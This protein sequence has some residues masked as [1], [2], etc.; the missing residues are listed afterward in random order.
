MGYCFLAECGGLGERNVAAV[1]GQTKGTL[2]PNEKVNLCRDPFGNVVIY[3]N[4]VNLCVAK[5]STF[6]DV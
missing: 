6:N 2:S 3:N 4:I 5:T 1:S